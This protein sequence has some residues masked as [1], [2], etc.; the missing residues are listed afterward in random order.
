MLYGLDLSRLGI[1]PIGSR[2][3]NELEQLSHIDRLIPLDISQL[4]SQNRNSNSKTVLLATLEK[5][6]DP[7]R[8]YLL[9]FSEQQEDSVALQ[10]PPH[11]PSEQLGRLLE[12]ALPGV[13]TL[14]YLYRFS[15]S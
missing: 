3:H 13:N 2:E 10:V 15:E 1:V 14:S 8:N 9:C 5:E 11:L 7:R 4:V 12:L 6:L